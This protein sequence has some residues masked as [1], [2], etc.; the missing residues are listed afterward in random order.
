MVHRGFLR[1]ENP[2]T[3]MQKKNQKLYGPR[4]HGSMSNSQEAVDYIPDTKNARQGHRFLGMH[5]RIQGRLRL[6]LDAGGRATTYVSRKLRRHVQRYATHI[7]K[8]LAFRHVWKV[9]RYY[10][11]RRNFWTKKKVYRMEQLLRKWIE[12]A[13]K[14]LV[15]I[16]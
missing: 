8:R 7:G 4:M 12:R 5:R 6:S 2:T 10:P 15:Y 16:T 3:K 13:V 11:I 1:I 9:W 14:E